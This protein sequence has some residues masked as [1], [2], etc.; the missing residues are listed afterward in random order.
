MGPAPRVAASTKLL[1][2]ADATDRADPMGTDHAFLTSPQARDVLREEGVA[3]VGYRA[4]Q[5]SWTA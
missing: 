3:V 5:R 1:G 4:L 2:L